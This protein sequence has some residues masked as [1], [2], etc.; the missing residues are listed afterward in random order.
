MQA[1]KGKSVRKEKQRRGR[2]LKNKTRIEIANGKAFVI[3]FTVR[4]GLYE[5][6]CR[7]SLF[8]LIRKGNI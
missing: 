2:E 6:R 3:L 5:A 1:E 7:L 4:I 8:F